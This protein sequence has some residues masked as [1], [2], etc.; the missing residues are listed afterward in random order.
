MNFYF[1]KVRV[2]W[3]QRNKL[4]KLNHFT[5]VAFKILQKLCLNDNDISEVE[6]HA[7]Y[8]LAYLKELHLQNN[9]IFKNCPTTELPRTLHLYLKGNPLTLHTVLQ[10]YEAV[11]ANIAE[12][13]RYLSVNM[14]RIEGEQSYI[15]CKTVT[16]VDQ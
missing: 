2:L 6:P 9:N 8:G 12:M 16:F 1:T 13:R 3:L 5:F 7:F 4:Q 11:S 15:S 14:D 10:G